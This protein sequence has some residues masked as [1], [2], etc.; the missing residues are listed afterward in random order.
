MGIVAHDLKAPL[1]RIKGYIQILRLTSEFNE[2]QK[3]YIEGIETATENGRNLIRDILD[4][5]AYEQQDF[6]LH[7]E[8]F[9][10]NEL[11][12]QTID[13]FS[14]E[15]DEKHIEIIS[16]FEDQIEL[17]SDSAL[18]SRVVE[19]LYSN[20]IKFSPENKHIYL[21]IWTEGD[22]AK[23]SIKDEGPGFN[24]EDKQKMFKK[25]QQLSAKP[26]GGE[27][28]TGLGLAIV[29]TLL[30]RLKGS[31]ELESQEKKGAEFILTFPLQ[32]NEVVKT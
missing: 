6:S 17:R 24:E 16:Q 8:D 32:I 25:F 28:S 29:K 7:L 14:L 15:S 13:S 3:Q 1:N 20:A 4:V 19:N 9:S 11:V 30:E 18:M 12:Q 21:K 2:E 10:L 5:S 26:T 22:A 27:N 23:L 31:V